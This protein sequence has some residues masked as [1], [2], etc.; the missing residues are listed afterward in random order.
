MYYKLQERGEET[1]VSLEMLG[2]SAMLHRE[3]G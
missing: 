1:G 2:V 3:R